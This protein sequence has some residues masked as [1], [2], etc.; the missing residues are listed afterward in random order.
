VATNS[1]ECKKVIADALTKTGSTLAG[2]AF[3]LHDF[4]FRGVVRHLCSLRLFAAERNVFCQSFY[5]VDDTH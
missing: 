5:W 2:I 3:K 4:G 1:R